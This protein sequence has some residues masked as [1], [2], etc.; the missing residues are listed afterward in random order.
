[1]VKQF[2]FIKNMDERCVY[3]KVSRSEVV[4]LIIYVDDILLIRNDVSLLQ[5]LSIINRI[6]LSKNLS[7]KDMIKVTYILGIKI[8]IDISKRLLGLSQSMYID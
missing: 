6:W 3:K 1:M 8:Y 7:M 4:S 5:L 2:D